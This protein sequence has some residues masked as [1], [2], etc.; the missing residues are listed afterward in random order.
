MNPTEL[1]Y[2]KTAAE[3]ASGFGLLIALY[4]TLAGNL[5]RAAMAQRAGDLEKRCSESSHA[6]LVIGHLED[7][8]NNGTGGELAEQLAAFY[9]SL[10]RKLV[11]AEVNKSPEILEEQMRAVLKIREN[12][13]QMDFRST[14]PNPEILPPPTSRV[15]GTYSGASGRIQGNWSA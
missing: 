5:Q 13:Q 9:A 4:D 8:V 2:R 15:A 10:R 14:I 6:L 11:V 1:F 12:W 7:W 3:G